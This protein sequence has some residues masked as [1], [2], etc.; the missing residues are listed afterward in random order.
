MEAQHEYQNPRGTS[1]QPTP[2]WTVPKLLFE[3]GPSRLT[4]IRNGL[5]QKRD[6]IITLASDKAPKFDLD[7]SIGSRK[8]HASASGKSTPLDFVKI[9]DL[10]GAI[11]HDAALSYGLLGYVK[12]VSPMKRNQPYAQ[13]DKTRPE[14]TEASRSMQRPCK[15]MVDV[16]VCDENRCQPHDRKRDRANETDVTEVGF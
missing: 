5:T 12:A 7:R 14:Q 9:H 2:F 6:Q 4:F 11:A 10:N 16:E 15:R 1:T 8:S 13:E 3:F